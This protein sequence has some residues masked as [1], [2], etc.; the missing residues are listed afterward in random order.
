MDEKL[1]EKLAKECIDG[2]WGT[3]RTRKKNLEEAGYE[4]EP[5]KNKVAELRSEKKTVSLKS[6]VKSPDES[7]VDKLDKSKNSKNK[8]TKNF[9]SDSSEVLESHFKDPEVDDDKKEELTL[10]PSE[11]FEQVKGKI[12]EETGENVK[13]LYDATMKQLKKFMITGQKSAA[14]ELY[15]RCL[16]LEKEQ[17]LID[18]GI[19]KYVKRSDIDNYID[20][21]ADDCVCVIEM[22][23]FDRTIPDDIIDTVSECMDIFDEFYIVFTDYTG[24]KRAKVKKEKRDKDPILFGNIFIDGKVSPKMYFLGDWIDDYCDLTLDKMISEIAKKESKDES[25][26]VFDITNEATLDSIEEQ[27]FGTTDRVKARTTVGKK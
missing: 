1:I 22:K 6:K 10:T 18:K 8:Y 17:K 27:L 2:K 3:G 26:I 13:R 4:Y 9:K 15:A 23:N 21:V 24:E 7:F 25:E 19:T 11:Y 16:Y 14:K 20:N 5:I 12:N